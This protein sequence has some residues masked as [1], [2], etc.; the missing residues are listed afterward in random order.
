[1]WVSTLCNLK[2][3]EIKHMKTQFGTNS[4][5]RLL[6]K[7]FIARNLS[8]GYGDKCNLSMQG[9]LVCT[10]RVMRRIP[11]PWIIGCDRL[12]RGK[13]TFCMKNV[14]LDLQ[15]HLQVRE[16]VTLNEKTSQHGLFLPA[17]KHWRTVTALVSLSISQAYWTI[18]WM[19]RSHRDSL[20]WSRRFDKEHLGTK[21]CSD[22]AVGSQ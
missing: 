21:V 14:T 2:F 3:T 11:S 18:S 20:R 19:S 6:F 8:Q 9:D 1:M 5:N 22:A 15:I 16:A 10:F 12:D 7:N 17:T 13:G 4:P